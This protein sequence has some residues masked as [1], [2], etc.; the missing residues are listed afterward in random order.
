MLMLEMS[1]EVPFLAVPYALL[2]QYLYSYIHV[3]HM[4]EA[5]R[6]YNTI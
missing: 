2:E 1:L 6:L 3:F 5:L 4:I